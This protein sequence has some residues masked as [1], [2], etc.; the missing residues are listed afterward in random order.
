MIRSLD[1]DLV[2][3]TSGM[4]ADGRFSGTHTVEQH[5]KLGCNAWVLLGSAAVDW[6][7]AGRRSFHSAAIFAKC[8]CK[9]PHSM[10]LKFP[11]HDGGGMHT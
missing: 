2:P 1:G 7:K 4:V 8:A 10:L 11:P 9:P 3:R 5:I 6:S